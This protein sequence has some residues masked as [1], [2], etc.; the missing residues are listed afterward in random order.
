MPCDAHPL[1]C[2]RYRGKG[3]GAFGSAVGA[4]RGGRTTGIRCLAD[5]WGRI[6]AIAPTPGNIADI[7]MALPIPEAMRPTRRLIADKACEADGLRTWLV[8][9][10]L[11]PVIPGRA[12]RNGVCPL[13][14]RA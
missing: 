8:E 7:A 10:P 11:E 14:S 1:L 13:D 5:A 4:S 12:A 6:V 9:R 2:Y 3:G